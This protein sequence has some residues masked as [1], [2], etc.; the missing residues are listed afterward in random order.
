M[1]FKTQPY[2]DAFR[3][4]DFQLHV[5]DVGNGD[6]MIIKSLYSIVVIPAIK[7]K[8]SS[9]N[10]GSRNAIV[11]KNFPLLFST[12]AYLRA[13]SLPTTQDTILN[14]KVLP[15]VKDNIL[16]ASTAIIQSTDAKNGP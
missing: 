6:A 5:I 12:E 10:S 15:N 16:P 9:G 4:Y 2:A 1:F 14:P 8:A 7:H 11:K 13:L 3:H